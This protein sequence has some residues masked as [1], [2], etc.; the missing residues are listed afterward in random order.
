MRNKLGI[1]K[2]TKRYL[3]INAPGNFLYKIGELP[4]GVEFIGFDDNGAEI[5]FAFLTRKSE[6]EELLPLLKYKIKKDGII[7][8]GYPKPDSGIDANINKKFVQQKAS[9]NGL[10]E[11]A[12]LQYDKRWEMLRYHLD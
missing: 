9:Q 4:E 1:T 2:S 7:W 12:Y 6:V 11:N 3:V 10:K 8:V 5:A